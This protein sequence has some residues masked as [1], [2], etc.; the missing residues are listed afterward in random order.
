M[1]S[2]EFLKQKGLIEE[3]NTEFIITMQDGERFDLRTLLGEF[4]SIKVEEE[5][6]DIRKMLIDEDFEILAEKV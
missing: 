4:A 6:E 5:K 2:L 3:G 1:N